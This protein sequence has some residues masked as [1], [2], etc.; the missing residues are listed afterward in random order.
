MSFNLLV[1]ILNQNKLI[2]LNYVDCKKNLDIILTVK[3]YKYVLNKKRLDVSTA[4]APRLKKERY[5]ICVKA[6]EMVHYYILAS[7]SSIL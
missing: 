5:E 6:D 4:N 7:M 1:I 2:G 3:G